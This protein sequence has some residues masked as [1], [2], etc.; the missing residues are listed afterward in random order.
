MIGFTL[1][2]AVL[3]I[4]EVGLMLKYI[5]AG[6]PEP[7]ELVDDPFSDAKK[8]DDKQLYFAY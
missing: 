5:K 4:I 1:L 6:A 8:D 3:A 2:Y 7:D